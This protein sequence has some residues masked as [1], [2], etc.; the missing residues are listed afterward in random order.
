MAKVAASLADQWADPQKSEEYYKSLDH[1]VASNAAS[2][3]CSRM[4]TLTER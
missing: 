4:R 2:F 1:V 3:P